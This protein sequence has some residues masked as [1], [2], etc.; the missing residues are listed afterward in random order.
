MPSLSRV[1][2]ADADAKAAQTL[3]LGFGRDGVVVEKAS[4]SAD[5]GDRLLRNGRVVMG[6]AVGRQE[7]CSRSRRAIG[8]QEGG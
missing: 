7:T 6:K 5:V 8:P 3:A 4:R 2:V 1:I